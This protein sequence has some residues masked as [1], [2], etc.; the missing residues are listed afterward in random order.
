M[1]PSN[2]HAEETGKRIGVRKR[3]LH[4]ERE[5]GRGEWER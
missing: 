1:S 3:R 4:K 5:K 2:W